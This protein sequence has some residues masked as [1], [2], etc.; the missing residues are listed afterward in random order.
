MATVEE[1]AR[2]VAGV[3]AS[4]D[5]LLLIA[6]WINERW[7]E[8]AGTTTLKT[9]RVTGELHTQP[10]VDEGTVNVTRDVPEVI[11]V[12]TSWDN[13]LNGLIFKAKTNWQKI[14][15]VVSPTE[16]ILAEPYS[17]DTTTGSGYH[18]VQNAYRLAEDARELGQFWHQRL[19]RPLQTT[20]EQGMGFTLGN[21]FQ[22]SNV[23]AFATEQTPDIDGVRRV[24]IYPYTRRSELINYVYWRKPPD[25]EFKQELPRFIDI[26]AFRE[27]V[28]VDVLR[29]AMWKATQDQE[30]RKAEIFR[31]DYRAQETRWMR[32]HKHRVIKK[33]SGAADEEFLLLNTRNHPSFGGADVDVIDNAWAQV[34]YGR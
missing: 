22:V 10:V 28:M 14:S 29:N 4:E 1:V 19:Y 30:L 32:D 15:H 9:L 21:R 24:E 7:K 20:N 25:L 12:G 31:N 17:E 13:T 16:L 6:T 33:D 8:L 23:P 2:H 3:T 34:W 18:I 11:G 5:D 26:E 27:G